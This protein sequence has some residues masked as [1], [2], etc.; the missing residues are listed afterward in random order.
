ME[1]SPPTPQAESD[2]PGDS[3]LISSSPEA[4]NSTSPGMRFGVVSDTHGRL[5]GDIHAVFAGVE[6]I[7]HCGDVGSIQCLYELR[8]IAPVCAVRGNM[9]SWPVAGELP[10]Q[11]LSQTA[12]GTV[13]LYHGTRY[14]HDNEAIMWGMEVM[15][16]GNQPRLFL[17]GHT[18]Q[19]LI[20]WRDGRLFI[21]PGS[22]THYPGP[23][24]PTAALVE[25]HPQTDKL[26]ARLVKIKK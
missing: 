4:D 19:P 22:T 8:T 12:F 18:H 7:F 5:P 26:Q 13:A 1:K 9:D 23:I 10:D 24:G 14:G 15:F 21:N 25:Y 17:F 16:V 3:P 11:S 6:M 2:K 20:E